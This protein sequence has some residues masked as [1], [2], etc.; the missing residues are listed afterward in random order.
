MGLFNNFHAY[1][2]IS[3]IWFRARIPSVFAWPFICF[4]SS[5]YGSLIMWL[6]IL[7]PIKGDFYTQLVMQAWCPVTQGVC[8]SVYTLMPWCLAVE[9]ASAK[10]H[11]LA[12][13]MFTEVTTEV[14]L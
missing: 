9:T 4:F 11:T 5:S 6:S 2:D 12:I 3:L 8:Y 1:E 14:R 7:I 13:Q 10:C